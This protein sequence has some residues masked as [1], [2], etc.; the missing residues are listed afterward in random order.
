M[1]R[2]GWSLFFVVALLWGLPYLFIRVAVQA[3]IDPVV[4][5][6]L[7]T[8]GGAVVLLPLAVR[9]HFLRSVLPRWPII[10]ALT[11]V[12]VTG[13]FL[14]ITIGEQSISSSL[15]GLIVAAEP[16]IVVVIVV[17]V[18]RL[19]PGKRASEE[20]IT[21]LRVAGLVI[22]F[23]GVAALLG[24]DAASGQRLG[25]AL[26]L[27]AASLYAVGALL[28]RR[29]TGG[30]DGVDPVGVITTILAINTILLT[31]FALGRL[32]KQAPAPTVTASLLA[33]AL[34]CTAAAFVAYFALI[35]DVGPA[36]ATVVFYL[37]PVVTITAG[38]IVL[39]E[40]LTPTTLLGLALIITGCWFA[41]R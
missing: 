24:V 12:Q 19:A 25:A 23:A 21:P 39:H 26:V 28:I 6:W 38:A 41:T 8:A 10:L 33:L 18:S 37:T 34:L 32:P 29:I 1:T 13:P 14:L 30:P 27:L 31:P 3:D 20:R 15:A 16:L 35:G 2:R 7:R 5:V 4:V 40:P 22:G 36:R 17:V 9:R 11:L